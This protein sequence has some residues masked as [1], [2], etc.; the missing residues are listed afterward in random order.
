MS[1][2]N[3][4]LMAHLMRRAGFG[5]SKDELIEISKRSYEDQVDLILDTEPIYEVSKHLMHRYQPDYGSPMGNSSNGASWL[6]KMI[7]S[8]SPFKEKIALFWHGIFATGYAKLANGIVLHD[9]I[10]MFSKFGLG[11][12]R[13]L[14]IE[15]SK[16]PAMIIW[17][18]NCESH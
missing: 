14:L 4:L 7:W 6:Y 8:D 12:Y 18:D 11:N 3:I 1:D 16:D 5:A 9:Q 13:D 2:K 15:L 17:L 10:K